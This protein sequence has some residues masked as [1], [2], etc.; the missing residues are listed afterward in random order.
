[1]AIVQIRVTEKHRALFREDLAAWYASDHRDLPWRDTDDPY[2]IW[3]SEVM[4]QQT[5]VDQ[6]EPYY[7]RFL[8]RFPSVRDLA[9]ASLDD[10][11]LC[12]EGLGYYSR[13]RNLHRAARTVVDDYAGEVPDTL[14]EIRR[15]PGVG[16]YTA[17]AILSIAF[18]RP[19]AV[20][21]GN[22]IRV[23]SRFF[24]MESDVK[25]QASRRSLQLAA[26]ELV[27]PDRPGDFNQALMELGA[28]ICTPRAPSC[29]MCPVA[30]ACE[31]R[32][33]GIPES[34]PVSSSRPSV[35]HFDVVVA[36]IFDG[37][38]RI[39]I[40]QRPQDAMLGGLWEFPGGKCRD[41][42]TLEDACVREVKE[43]LGVDV[44]I[45]DFYDRL[46]HAYSHFRITLHA[47]RCVIADGQVQSVAGEA[48]DWVH[49]DSLGNYAFPRAN[50]RLIER[51]VQERREPRLF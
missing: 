10:V 13:A 15:L 27:D 43:E 42:E 45:N 31:A 23:L 30:A 46:V 28:R 33:R 37:S 12:W 2:R 34:F 7:R 14:E 48:L 21:D 5:R 1:V 17:A 19:H 41:D 35:P 25:K 9:D 20:L 44:V 6:V 8:E 4:L 32:R 22:V 11:L 26:D 24:A 36:L 18:E 50:R 39:L 49:V 16:P 40:Q 3:L 47:Y 51:I 29:S 38:G